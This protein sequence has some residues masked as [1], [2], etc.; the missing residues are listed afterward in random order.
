[1]E[2]ASVEFDVETLRPTYRLLIGIPG[3]SNAFEISRRLGLPNHIIV[4]SK[5]LI[6]DETLK[7]EDLIQKLQEKSIKA[8]RDARIAEGLKR[9]NEEIRE[10]LK[11]KLQGIDRI[12]INA[13]SEAKKEARKI[14]NEAKDE[15]DEILKNLRDLEKLGYSSDARRKLEEE[16]KR[17]KDNLDKLDTAKSLQGKSQGKAL[18]N[19]TPGDSAYLAK[20]DQQ[21]IILTKPDSKGEVQ[22]Q[23]GI[24]KIN[25]KLSELTESKQKEEQKANKRREVN[26]NL[27]SVNTSIDLRGMDSEEALYNTDKYLDEA[28]LGG[29]SEVTVIHGKGTGILRKTINDM[30]RRHPHV[31][32]FRL[33]EYGEGGTG[34]TVVTLK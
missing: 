27:K 30:L 12:R 31:E 15:A 6:S 2:N 28:Y 14:I 16:R 25:V 11:S 9:E 19:A 34:V 22:V 24:M 13:Q 21:V 26:L 29:L 10:K 3:K 33:G 23:A 32:D 1:M 20:L 17:L 5:E 4:S 8:E 7:F 18:K